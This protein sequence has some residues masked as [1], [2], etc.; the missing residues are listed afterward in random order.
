MKACPLCAHNVLIS[1]SIPNA[2]GYCE[3][4]NC[5]LISLH[6]NLRPNQNEERK[7][8]EMHENS[9]DNLQYREFLNRALEPLLPTLRNGMRGLDYG[10]GPEPVVAAMLTESGFSIENYD[11]YFAPKEFLA[12][13]QYDFIISTETIEH[14]HIPAK[15][16]RQVNQL[17]APGGS[18]VIM[19]EVFDGTFPF[20][21]WW[22]LRDF[23]HVSFYQPQT[24][25]WIAACYNWRM[26]TPHK[27]VRIFRKT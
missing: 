16:F 27:N 20:E 11:P 4:A 10:S 19:T 5:G 9:I 2:R 26:E 1:R 17:L 7:R 24:F 6:P 14:F 12:T 13:D 23:T 18:L 15:E 25:V 22:Y 8:Y 3:C 21:T